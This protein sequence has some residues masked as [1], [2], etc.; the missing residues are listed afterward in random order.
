MAANKI[1]IICFVVI[2]AGNSPVHGEFPAQRPVTWSFDIFFD[3]RPNKWLSK[4][5][6]GWWFETLS[7]PFLR[8][9]NEVR[10]YSDSIAFLCNNYTCHYMVR[11]QLRTQ[12]NIFNIDQHTNNRLSLFSIHK[13]ISWCANFA[14]SSVNLIHVIS[15][16]SMCKIR[17][18]QKVSR[19]LSVF[20]L[21]RI[22]KWRQIALII[23]W[24][25]NFWR[26]T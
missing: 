4:Q 5:S 22:L 25:T 16:H 21:F 17:L 7:C 20:R 10:S 2:C 3:L 1:A 18:F 6:W 23:D 8:H 24:I 15:L 9:C 14:W 19:F 13:C 11:R 26:T 12:Q